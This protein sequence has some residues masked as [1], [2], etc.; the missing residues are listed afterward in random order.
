MNL[1]CESV[2]ENDKLTKRAELTRVANEERDALA[3]VCLPLSLAK[4][5]S[6]TNLSTNNLLL[7]I[8]KQVDDFWCK[9]TFAKRLYDHFM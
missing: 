5:N 1:K 4:V 6:C 2:I 7:L 3:Q 9:L 8:E